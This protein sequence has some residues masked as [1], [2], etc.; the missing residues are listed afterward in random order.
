MKRTGNRERGR[1]RKRKKGSR[2]PTV[3]TVSA[4]IAAIAAGIFLLVRAGEGTGIPLTTKTAET[5]ETAEA[6]S[7]ETVRQEKTQPLPVETPAV[8]EAETES[9]PE[10]RPEDLVTGT[11][12]VTADQVNIRKEAS[13]DSIVIGKLPRGAEIS[14][15]QTDGD[16][17]EAVADG[18][19]CYIFAGYLTDDKDWEEH[20]L[21]SRGFK[22]R[23]AVRLD[24][25]WKYAEFSEISTDSAVMYLAKG[26][27]KGI[28]IG[29][30]A[31]HGTAGGAKVKTW[32]HPDK[33]PKVTGG[34]TAAGETKAV[35]VSSGMVFRDGT[36]EAKVTLAEA[37]ILKELLLENG[38]DVLMIR[39]SGDVQ[40]DNVARTV[41]C[42][43]AADCHIA[44]HWD[45]DGLD[46][47]KGCFYMSVPEGIKYLPSVASTWEESE[48]LGD[49]LIRGLSERENR[50]M[51]SGCM[52]MDLTQTSYSTVPSVDIEL[53]NQS[54]DHGNE[55][56]CQ[57]AEGLLK[58]IDLY[59]G[60]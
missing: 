55:K 38:Y 58:G 2:L 37:Q 25:S 50:I 17:V 47:D 18:Q 33:T 42:N 53:G 49:A 26:D 28:T 11:M 45:G 60:Y 32:C 30:N 12:Y 39:D 1:S 7:A 6:S 15:V 54:S 57:L 10:T 21:S 5:T 20:L 43:N 3:L 40:L 19:I 14:V 27:R 23:E 51:G 46:Y 41:I 16:W 48:K 9:E 13:T 36:G 29:L 4:V 8:T 59:F 34:T 24:P 56:L 35:A 22:D 44:I 52:D 31:G